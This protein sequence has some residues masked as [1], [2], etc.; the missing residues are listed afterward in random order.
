MAAS[1][2]NAADRSVRKLLIIYKADRTAASGVFGSAA[3]VMGIYS[4]FNVCC[5]A[6]IKG[7]V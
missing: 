1:L 5:P 2:F 3:A 7:A 6:G 4:G